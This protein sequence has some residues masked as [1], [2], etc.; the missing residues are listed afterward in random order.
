M[1]YQLNNNLNFEALDGAGLLR[2]MS[3][4]ELLL[5]ENVEYV[6]QLNVFP[7]PDGDT[8]TNMFLTLKSALNAARQEKVMSAE[9][10]AEAVAK[11]ALL[12]AKGNS[13][14]ILSQFFRG[15]ANGLKGKYDFRVQDLA[16]A[17][18][19]AKIAAYQ[20]VAEPLEG[21]LLTVIRRVAKAA[22]QVAKQGFSMSKALAILSETA[23]RAVADTPRYLSVLR[24][25]EVVD[26]GGQG[27]LVILEGLHRAASSN[28]HIVDITPKINPRAIPSNTAILHD[29][30]GYCTNFMLIGQSIDIMSLKTQ[31]TSLGR[32]LVVVGDEQ[33]CRIHIHTLDPGAILSSALAFGSLTQIQ[34]D[35][36]DEQAKAKDSNRPVPTTS[37]QEVAVVAV[38]WGKGLI[39]IFH[40]L[41]VRH[42]IQ[43]GDSMNPSI[44]EIVQE[45][46]ATQA[47]KVI[48]LPNNPNIIAAALQAATLAKRQVKVIA[49]KTIPEGIAAAMAFNADA[50]FL[51]NE[52]NMT[53]AMSR[54]KSGAVTIASRDVKLN[55]VTVKQ[56]QFIALLQNKLVASDPNLITVILNLLSSTTL[57]A[58][59]LITFYAGED[60]TEATNTA[61]KEAIKNAYPDIELEFV[62]GGQPYYPYFIA[63]E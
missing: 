21:T 15:F 63:I 54:L 37:T 59:Q 14:V 35:N 44:E 22:A 47:A 28:T 55:G 34:I 42:I 8:G 17:F 7:V 45:I 3:N 2:L 32:S 56:G 52:S 4:A 33:Q 58:G 49:S 38:A 30:Y 10:I 18:K 11:G 46:E 39:D 41:G 48:V 57:E 43:A 61:I 36:M 51:L 31:L 60:S 50:E 9:N 19:L 5:Q 26:A 12:G 29:D 1:D 25:A 6:N 27:L 23:K 16:L 13:G 40:N 62:W 53:A 20:A 24:E